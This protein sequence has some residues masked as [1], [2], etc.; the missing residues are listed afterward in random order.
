M[1][2]FVVS[3]LIELQKEIAKISELDNGAL[4]KQMLREGSK[5]V[6]NVWHEEAQRRHNKHT[7]NMNRSIGSSNPK[8]NKIGRYTV[9]Y[10]MGTEA[11]IRHGVE[12]KMR[13]AEKAFY[14]HYGYINPWN[15]LFYSGD[16]W[17]EIVD[18]RSEPLVDKTMQQIFDKWLR[19]NQK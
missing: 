3:G 4:A 8:K 7:G 10:P 6:A 18:M 14:Q 2:K 19:N 16:R 15:G 12:I 5:D 13:D 11:R 17:V 9:T 1:A